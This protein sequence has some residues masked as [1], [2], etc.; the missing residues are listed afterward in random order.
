MPSSVVFGELKITWLRHAGFLLAGRGK[1]VVIDPFN[2]KPEKA[3]KVDLTFVTH[4]HFDHCSLKDLE[5]F[6]DRERTSVVAAR[7]CSRALKDLRCKTKDFVDPGGS[8]EVA[9]VKFQAVPA[10]NVNKFRSP[11][12]PFHP[13]NYGGVGY[14]IEVAGARVYHAG[15]TDNIPEMV[16]LKDIDVALLPVSG[17]YVMTAEEAAEAAKT[18]TPKLAIPMHFGEIVG[19][20]EDAK[21]FSSLAGVKVEVLEPGM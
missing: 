17:T 10:Y 20:I 13:R 1:T 18:I 5:P 8:G 15:D 2:V 11:G 21:R 3:V 6:V 16:Q 7:N 19:S 12:V 4:D 9:G 14:V